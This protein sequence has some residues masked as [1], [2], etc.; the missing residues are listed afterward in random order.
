MSNV[1]SGLCNRLIP[2][3]PLIANQFRVS[4]RASTWFP[5]LSLDGER[6]QP[7]QSFSC[8]LGKKQGYNSCVHVYPTTGT[9]RW[10][11]KIASQTLFPAFGLGLQRMESG[12]MISIRW[13]GK[14]ARVHI[15]I[16]HCHFDRV[17]ELI[18][19]PTTTFQRFSVG[20]F[21]HTIIVFSPS[22]RSRR[23]AE[24]SINNCGPDHQS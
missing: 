14:R 8:W 1:F 21:Y 5:Y 10:W 7:F 16:Q 12:T 23:A 13:R 9:D 6:T 19:L 2:V 15:F 18:P 11:R 22:A 4:R 20:D 3:F 17:I 24:F